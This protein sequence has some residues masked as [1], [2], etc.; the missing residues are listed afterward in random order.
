MADLL[1]LQKQARV[2][3]KVLITYNIVKNGYSDPN[4]GSAVLFLN[5]IWQQK[6]VYPRQESK[7]G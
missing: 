1:S 5:V 2:I 7:I 3:N 4:G 6:Q